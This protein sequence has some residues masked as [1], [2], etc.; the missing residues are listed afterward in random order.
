M[1]TQGYRVVFDGLLADDRKAR[2][3]A[4][5]AAKQAL[6][7][8]EAWWQGTSQPSKDWILEKLGFPEEMCADSRGKYWKGLCAAGIVDDEWHLKVGLVLRGLGKHPFAWLQKQ[9]SSGLCICEVSANIMDMLQSVGSSVSISKEIPVLRLIRYGYEQG[10]LKISPFFWELILVNRDAVRTRVKAAMEKALS[11]DLFWS[12]GRRGL[13]GRRFLEELGFPQEASR[14]ALAKVRKR[15]QVLGAFPLVCHFKAAFVLY[16]LG[17]DPEIWVRENASRAKRGCSEAKQLNDLLSQRGF[18]VRISKVAITNLARRVR[19]N[20]VGELSSEN[21][22][23]LRD[24][25][26]T[27][28]QVREDVSRVY[29]VALGDATFWSKKGIVLKRWRFVEE[30]AH[31][32]LGHRESTQVWEHLT[33]SGIV[34]PS[35]SY[36]F[37]LALKVLGEEPIK[38]MKENYRR[39]ERG[40]LQELIRV[41]N[42]RLLS[43]GFA[44]QFGV[45]ESSVSR[46]VNFMIQRNAL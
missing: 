20:R 23:L 26:L 16:A 9:L 37:G 3:K 4:L 15:L 31:R 45:R 11:D 32:R 34:D 40:S 5:K 42:H 41:V 19:E 28:E 18:K 7:D 12:G 35:C 24:L 13:V 38:W 10:V 21:S 44:F 8:P 2:N 27:P 46:F 29:R 1:G 33:S 36:A 14:Q 43:A 17:F 30:V 6:Y 22:Q 25:G 39:G